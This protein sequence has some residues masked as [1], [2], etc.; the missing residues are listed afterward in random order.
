[1]RIKIASRRSD[2]ARLQAQVVGAAL[3]RANQDLVI[4]FHYRESLG[5]INQSDPLW[6]MPERGVFTEDFREGLVSGE[7]DMVVHSWK[8][9]PVES[10]GQTEIIATL[11]RADARDLL[12][13]RKDVRSRLLSSKERGQLR[14]LSS[15]PRRKYNL[16]AC[17][18]RL[19]PFQNPTLEFIPVRGNVPTRFEKL[20]RGE[21][22]ALVMAKAALDRLL[23]A[24]GEEFQPTRKAL[25]VMLEQVDWMVLPLSANPAAAA[26][27]ALAVEIKLGRPDLAKLFSKVHCAETFQDVSLEREILSGHGGGCH[28]KIGATVFRT[29]LGRV[30][31]L[32]GVRED[33]RVLDEFRAL[34]SESIPPAKPHAYFPKPDEVASFFSRRDLMISQTPKAKA[35][36]IAK[37]DALPEHWELEPDTILWAAGLT[38]WERLA[39][40]GLWVH[41]S[42]DSLGEGDPGI[43][44]IYGQELKLTKLTHTR[45]EKGFAAEMIGT[46]ELLE[47]D[48]V[49][50]IKSRTHFFWMSGS[51]FDAA[52]RR[53]P[54][55]RNSVHASGPGHTQRHLRAV[56]GKEA[57]IYQFLSIEDWKKEI[58]K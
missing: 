53:Y 47:K 25:R 24:N 7:W 58:L 20:L 38:T 28:Q 42:F 48:E 10:T 43:S 45:G 27:G 21:G 4:D 2:L 29:E 13:L 26:Q 52:I 34:D 22:D 15:S 50:D 32:R 30:L 46:Y 17:L 16:E 9:L 14:I 54:E 23:S 31:S 3:Q 41:G 8:D 6:K 56:L 44:T 11:P 1:M 33:G 18:P 35:L 57:K 51:Q 5:D 49:I 36:L 19:L 40:R 55:I 37:A 12:L 39:R